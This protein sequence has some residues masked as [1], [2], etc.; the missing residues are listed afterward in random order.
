L[1]TVVP[2]AAGA[3][4]LAASTGFALY[5]KMRQENFTQSPNGDKDRLFGQRINN[6]SS[7]SLTLFILFFYQLFQ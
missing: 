7:T 5:K 3:C 6:I 1:K 4:L 2:A